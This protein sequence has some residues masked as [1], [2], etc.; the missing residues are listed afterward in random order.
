MKRLLLLICALVALIGMPAVSWADDVPGLT[1]GHTYSVVCQS[2]ATA[3]GNGTAIDVGGLSTV[4][5]QV[6]GTF[7]ATLTFES[8]VDGATWSAM[9]VR[10]Q[11]TGS[12]GTT[13]TS[14]G[15]YLA[16][17]AALSKVRARV[18]AYASGSVTVLARATLAQVNPLVVGS[19]GGMSI[20]S[21]VTSG[22]NNRLLYVDGSGNLAS[23]DFFYA[24][25]GS[26]SPEISAR[27]GSGASNSAFITAYSMDTSAKTGV[28]GIAAFG[29]NTSKYIQ[30]LS[31]GT[32]VTGPSQMGVSPGS[33]QS[34]IAHG[35]PL[36]I[37]TDATTSGAVII[38]THNAPAITIGTDQTTSFHSKQVHDVADPSSAQD[39]ATKTY[40]DGRVGSEFFLANTTSDLTM[41][42]NADHKVVPD[43]VV[44]DTNSIY[45]SGT[46]TYPT[47][48]WRYVTFSGQYENGSSGNRRQFY[49][50]LN[51]S[52][53][54]PG[55]G[56]AIGGDC[57]PPIQGNLPCVWSGSILYHFS[58]GDTLEVYSYH[59]DGVDLSMMVYQLSSVKLSSN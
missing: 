34:I 40:V 1:T 26:N 38:G 21:A 27:S 35:G 37:G 22:T 50:V 14:A 2:A 42:T 5:F 32:S 39:V 15:I 3:T 59:D 51:S 46:I 53:G 11:A 7:S 54:W 56:T 6:T 8:S 20:G 41:T 52:G 29:E 31:N 36:V 30:V 13:A 57:R 58:A 19:G 48:G 10:N 4:S 12:D 28:A 33:Q 18:S 44:T 47:D 25:T 45:S 23:S 9:T 43:N 17:A 16:N 24:T 49:F 55:T